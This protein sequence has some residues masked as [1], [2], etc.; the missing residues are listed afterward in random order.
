MPSTN[1]NVPRAHFHNYTQ[2][3]NRQRADV[4]HKRTS[5]VCTTT[6]TWVVHNCRPG[7][8][9][10]LSNIQ[11]WKPVDNPEG[12]PPEI[13]VEYIVYTCTYRTYIHRYARCI[14]YYEAKRFPASKLRWADSKFEAVSTISWV[15]VF[16][17]SSKSSVEIERVN[18]WRY[19]RYA[20]LQIII[21]CWK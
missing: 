18:F 12:C 17:W 10:R 9:W 15:A 19:A 7:I 21:K 1:F 11:E 8:P 4:C 5:Q 16:A 3:G 13:R 20:S 2:S 14:Y 6:L